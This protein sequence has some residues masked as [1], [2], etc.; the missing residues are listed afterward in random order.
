[1]PAKITKMIDA[2]IVGLGRWGQNHVNS[3]Q[4][5]S[6]RLRFVRGVVRH[7]DAVRDF[8]DKHRLAMSSDYA[9]LLSDPKI[10]A[11]VLATPNSLHADQI[12]A[13]AH[14]GK[15]VFCE[16]PLAL[17]RADA[18]RAVQACRQSGVVL[19]VGQDKR[20][21]PS[22]RELKRV[23]E[24]GELGEVLHVEGHFS[25]DNARKYSIGWRESPGEA[26]AGSMTSTGIHVLDA[27][28]NLVGPVRRVQ[29]QLISRQSQSIL[30]D[31][32][33]ML[34]EFENGV[35]GVLCSV[36]VTPLYWRVHVFGTEG[37]AEA[38]GDTGLVLHA[39]G[40]RPR[41]LSFDPVNALH[42]ELEAFA[43]AVA[44]GAAYPVP[45]SQMVQTVSALE[46][47][48]QAIK[49]RAPVTLPPS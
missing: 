10:Q 1:M 47:I 9:E 25:N 46:A 36:R 32:L 37:S 48:T 21:W 22:M 34:L 39:G 15:A 16:K 19:G 7:P 27:F 2:A 14:A 24:S 45:T 18:E 13:A 12:V 26:P 30:L 41:R 3:I 17:T 42:Y 8:A 31:T 20:F 49:S 40:A 33:A 28:V 4:G 38:L 23:V 29:A 6:D 5:K 44:G 43:D 35:S 11:I